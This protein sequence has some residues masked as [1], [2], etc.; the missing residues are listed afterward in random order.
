[1]SSRTPAFPRAARG[2]V[3]LPPITLIAHWLLQNFLVIQRSVTN[4]LLH[5]AFLHSIVLRG[6]LNTP[7]KGLTFP[8]IEAAMLNFT[9][10]GNGPRME[11]LVF[12]AQ[13]RVQYTLGSYRGA[14]K[15]VPQPRRLQKRRSRGF[16]TE[17]KS[18]LAHA[19]FVRALCLSR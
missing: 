12:A 8:L 13:L 19:A 4:A 15:N 3:G 16:R 7:L 1:M 5:V 2:E 9:D 18:P 10:L 17:S 6:I 14:S 11:L